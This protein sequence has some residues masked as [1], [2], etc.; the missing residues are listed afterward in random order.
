[1]PEVS[2]IEEDSL[3]ARPIAKRRGEIFKQEFPAEAEGLHTLRA[4]SSR[5][6]ASEA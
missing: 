6:S 3:A 5:R 1:M 2:G 4:S